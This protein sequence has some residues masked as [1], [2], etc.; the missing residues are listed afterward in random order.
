MAPNAESANDIAAITHL[1]LN[2]DLVLNVVIIISLLV[3]VFFAVCRRKRSDD[4]SI[5][6]ARDE[7]DCVLHVTMPDGMRLIIV[8]QCK[9]RSSLVSTAGEEGGAA[10]FGRF[11]WR[12]HRRRQRRSIGKNDDV[13]KDDNC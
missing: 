13:A 4:D 3:Y 2:I 12:Q 1:V 8:D 5:L 6:I 11:R 9:R 7:D 10:S